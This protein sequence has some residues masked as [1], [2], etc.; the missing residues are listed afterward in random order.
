MKP[1]DP[2]ATADII[3]TVEKIRADERARIVAWLRDRAEKFTTTPVPGKALRMA[4]DLIEH[5]EL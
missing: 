4:A 5:D 3:A 1:A 2:L